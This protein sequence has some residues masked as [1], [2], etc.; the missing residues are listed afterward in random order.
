MKKV[1]VTTM[2]LA[3]TMAVMAVPAKDL[4]ANDPETVDLRTVPSAV[5]TEQLL[6][7][8]NDNIILGDI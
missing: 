8:E 5:V 7:E 4:A 6:F 1:L 3:M 2:M